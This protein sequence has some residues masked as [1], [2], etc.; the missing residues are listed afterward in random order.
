MGK[1]IS[2]FSLDEMNFFLQQRFGIGLY[3]FTVYLGLAIG[4]LG[5]PDATTLKKHSDALI[6][7]EKNIIEVLFECA[8]GAFGHKDLKSSK[9]KI[10]EKY[11]LKPF[12]DLINDWVKENELRYQIKKMGTQKG[13][14]TKPRNIIAT[15][16]GL[17]ISQQEKKVDWTIIADLLDWFW[18]RLKPYEFYQE[19]KPAA[20]SSDPQ[21]LRTQTYRNREKGLAYIK[22]YTR[23]SETPRKKGIQDRL[24][25]T[26]L[27]EDFIVMHGHEAKSSLEQSLSTK[28]ESALSNGIDLTELDHIEKYWAYEIYAENLLATNQASPPLVI[29]PDFSYCS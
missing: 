13:A 4:D 12:F 19:L 14:E 2:E 28:I 25:I 11:E 5:P 22:L 18:E 20:E 23:S 29:F 1:H 21:S 3:S 16:W 15:V 10:E 26:I 24:T 8:E 6:E 7:L 27:G 17:L 9:V